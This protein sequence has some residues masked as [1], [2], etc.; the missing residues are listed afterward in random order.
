MLSNHRKGMAARF[1]LSCLML[2]STAACSPTDSATSFAISSAIRN[3]ASE[4]EL[5]TLEGWVGSWAAAPQGPYP[6]GPLTDTS[7]G[8][9][10]GTIT[11]AQFSNNEAVD[12]SFRMIIRPTLGGE[13]V[14]VRLSNAMGTQAVQ[15]TDLSLAKALN[16]S[17]AVLPGTTRQLLFDGRSSITIPAGGEATSD[18]LPFP[19]Q[20]G[21]DLAVSF[22]VEGRSGPMTWHAVSFTPNYVS[23][24]NSGSVANDES[25]LQM[26]S[27]SFG[28]FFLS[29]LDVFNPESS[30]SLVALGDSITDGFFQTLNMRWTDRLAERLNTAGIKAGVLNQGIN[31]NTVTNARD[32]D[33]G[34]PANQRFE[35]DVLNMP[36]VKALLLF[37]GTNDLGAKVSSSELI[38]AYQELIARARAKNLCVL[39]ATIPPRADLL[40]GWAQVASTQEPERVKVN[41]WI[42]NTPLIDGVVDFEAVLGLPGMKNLPNPILYIPD[43]LHP[44]SLGFRLMGDAVPLEKLEQLLKGNCVK[45]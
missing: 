31:S 21:E 29:G 5:R 40:F 7:G 9:I 11:L 39:M 16:Y 33:A 24:P 37:E 35:R 26:A 14:R 3:Q 36:G 8:A 2:C 44:N 19:F 12:Q 10:P 6:S 23:Q 30:G 43:L 4:L 45:G 42:R 18:A 13:Q 15:F 25:G 38:Q 34:L 22:H 28:W 1:L 32:G 27:P 17:P 20:F 41:E